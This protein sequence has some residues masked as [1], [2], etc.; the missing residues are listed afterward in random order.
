MPG[1]YRKSVDAV[2]RE[3]AGETLLV[4]IRGH[5]ADLRHIFSLNPVGSFVWDRLDGE[6]D[7]EALGSAVTSAFEVE[8][9]RAEA[10]VRSF[11][12]QLVEAGL[13]SV[14]ERVA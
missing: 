11:L 8:P 10:D 6:H 12:G 3:I 13:A 14:A 2:T 9:G 5:L 1:V 7:A 4:P